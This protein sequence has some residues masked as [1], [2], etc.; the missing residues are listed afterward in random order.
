MD[1]NEIF[2]INLKFYV[3][4]SGKTQ[5]Q[6]ALD[7]GVSKGTFSDWASGRSHPR[8]NR[9]QQIADYFGVS[10][11]DLVENGDR[12]LSEE[13]ARIIR[14]VDMNPLLKDLLYA[15]TKLDDDDLEG[16]IRLLKRLDGKR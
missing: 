2:S 1:S 5:T 8:M 14:T 3:I 7:L 13:T 10:T 15:A 12:G 16:I 4:K 6:I 9:V 11:S